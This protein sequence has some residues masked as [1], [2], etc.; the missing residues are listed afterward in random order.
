MLQAPASYKKVAILITDGKS[1][2]GGS[3]LGFAEQ[4]RFL[5]MS[6]MNLKESRIE[7]CIDK[8]FLTMQ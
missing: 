6:V 3:P 4:M 7:C 1:N 5:K 2:T 8:I